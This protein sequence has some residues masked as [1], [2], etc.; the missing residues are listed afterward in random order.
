MQRPR[1]K[2]SNKNRENK[3]DGCE[4]LSEKVFCEGKDEIA[5]ND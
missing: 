1:G 5:A 2:A 3:P 4:Y